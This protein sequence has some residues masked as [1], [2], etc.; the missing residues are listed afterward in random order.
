MIAFTIGL[1]SLDSSEGFSVGRFPGD[2]RAAVVVSDGAA[3]GFGMLVKSMIG[4]CLRPC[5]LGDCART[6]SVIVELASDDD[7]I[8][9]ELV[10]FGLLSMT[11]VVPDDVECLP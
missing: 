7:A 8:A 9:G 11:I 5:F 10:A 1:T 2:G 4:V 3:A 6:S